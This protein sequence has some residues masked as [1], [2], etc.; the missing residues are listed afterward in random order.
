MA[1]LNQLTLIYDYWGCFFYST[2]GAPPKGGVGGP[3][4][5]TDPEELSAQ[6]SVRCQARE[7]M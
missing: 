3:S 6:N 5:G 4:F 1:S 7:E 2:V